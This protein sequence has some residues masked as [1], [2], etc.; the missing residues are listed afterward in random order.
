MASHSTTAKRSRAISYIVTHYRGIVNIPE[1]SHTWTDWIFQ[2]CDMFECS[3]RTAI[4]YMYTARARIARSLSEDRE[5][6]QKVADE[7]KPTIELTNEELEV[8]RG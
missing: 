6:R 8:L 5:L 7:L 2:I 3:R 1:D 4:E